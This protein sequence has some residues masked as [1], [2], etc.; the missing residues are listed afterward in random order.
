MAWGDCVVYPM[1]T[2]EDHFATASRPAGGFH[3][4]SENTVLAKRTFGRSDDLLHET[5]V[6][7]EKIDDV[8]PVDFSARCRGSLSLD[9]PCELQ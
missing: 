8:S 1:C 3:T 9:P 6:F 2:G 4:A 7:V 5:H